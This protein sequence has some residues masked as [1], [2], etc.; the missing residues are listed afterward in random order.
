[1][2]KIDCRRVRSRGREIKEATVIVQEREVVA[3]E[4]RCILSEITELSVDCD[5]KIVMERINCKILDL[6]RGAVCL[7]E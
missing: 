6:E 7:Y 5:G 4:I 3:V 1:M 2:L